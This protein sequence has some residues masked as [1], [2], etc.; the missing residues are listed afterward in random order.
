MVSTMAKIIVPTIK[1]PTFSSSAQVL[2]PTPTF[3]HVSYDELP[4]KLAQ[5]CTICTIFA[6]FCSN[7]DGLL[8]LKAN[9]FKPRN[10]VFQ[11]LCTNAKTNCAHK[12]SPT[13]T[14][15]TFLV[16]HSATLQLL[17]GTSFCT[18]C[19][20]LVQPPKSRFNKKQQPTSPKTPFSPLTHKRKNH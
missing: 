20:N 11:F 15:L 18:K 4:H 6:Q 13:Q 10:A 3:S 1:F 2:L 9:R 8:Y 19:T 7:A 16:C 14:R 5:F 12:K 17:W